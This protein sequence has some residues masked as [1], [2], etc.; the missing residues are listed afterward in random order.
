MFA[1]DNCAF[2]MS[3]VYMGCKCIVWLMCVR[4]MQNRMELFS[5]AAKLF[6]WRKRLRPQKARS[7]R[8]W[9]CVTTLSGKKFFRGSCLGVHAH[10]SKC[11]RSTRPGKVL[12]PFF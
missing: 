7:S 8:C 12:E 1:D 10:L 5:T 6:E 11:W 3:Q 4:L 9:Y 2:S